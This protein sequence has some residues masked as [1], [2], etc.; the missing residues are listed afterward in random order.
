MKPAPSI[1]S[2]LAQAADYYRLQDRT[3]ELIAYFKAEA[4]RAWSTGERLWHWE[5][6]AHVKELQKMKTNMRK[7][8]P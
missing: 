6:V 7:P 5:C 4:N 1:T 3:D 8:K 2:N